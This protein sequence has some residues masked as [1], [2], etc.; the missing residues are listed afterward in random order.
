MNSLMNGFKDLKLQWK[1]ALGF[2]VP[3][4]LIVMIAFTVSSN[5][6]KLLE[7]NKWVEHTYK[8]IDLGKGITSSLVNMETGFRG[9]LVVGDKEFLEPFVSGQK[10]FTELMAKAK[11]MVSDNPTQVGR[12]K[13]VEGMQAGWLKEHVNIAMELRREVNA[14]SRSSTSIS[15]FINKGIGK[16]YM[17][18]MRVILDDFV[19][20]ES[21]LIV[22][23]GEE[24]IETA[25]T[26]STVTILGAILAVIIG[27]FV[28]YLITRMITKPMLK[29]TDALMRAQKTGDFNNRLIIA[30]KDEVGQA[31]EAFNLL[32][33]NLRD[34]FKSI[35]ESTAKFSKGDLGVR[36]ETKMMGDLQGMKDATNGMMD[37]IS[38]NAAA[39]V[40]N[41]RN[42]QALDVCQANVMMADA[43]LNIVYLNDSVKEMLSAAET[44]IQKDLPN[45]NVSSLMGFNVDGFHKNPSHQR[46]M[47][48]NLKEVYRTEIKV[49]GRAFSLVATPVFDKGERLGTVVEWNDR[50][51]ELVRLAEEQRIAADSFRIKRALD[52]CQANVMMADENNDI[53]YT[54]ET[55]LD[56][57]GTAERDIRKDLPNFRANTVN[58]SNIDIFHKNPA[59]QRGMLESLTASYDTQIEVGGRTFALIATPVFDDE[60]IRLGTVVEWND[61]TEELVRLAEEQQSAAENARV[62]QALDNLT[63][64]TMIADGDNNIVY[65]NQAV[66]D[67]LRN[68]EN[69]LRRELTNFNTDKVLGSNIDVFHK[70]PAHQRNM[71]SNLKSTY[72]TEIEVAGRTFGLIA[73]PVVDVD[74]NRIGTVVEWMDRTDEV[75]IEREID[76]VL[77][78]A[79]RGDLT[80]RIE[81]KGKDG[82]FKRLSEGLNGL[83]DIADGV[84]TETANVLGAMAQGDMTKTIDSDY[85][86]AFDQLKTDVNT[87]GERL[88]EIVGKISNSSGTIRT[89]A[90]EIAQGNADLSQRTEEQASSL[91]ETASSMEEMTS[92]V[93]QSAEN[94][95]TA[96]ELSEEAR[97]KASQGGDVVQR[98]IT[99]MD[100]INDSSKKIADIIGV[101]DEIAFQTNL[102]ALNAAVEAARAG[103][104][105]RGFAVVAGEVRNLAQ[106]SAGAAKEIKDL[107]R[108]SVDKVTDGSK[109]VNESGETLQEIVGAVGK[110]SD[111]IEGI[112]QAAEEQSAGIEQVNKAITQMDEMTQ[113]NAAL[114]EEASAAG[115]AMADQ[116]RGMQGLMDFFT[117]GNAAA[118]IEMQPVKSHKAA[119]RVSSA[120]L[121]AVKQKPAKKAAVP[122][123]VQAHKADDDEWEEF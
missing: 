96:N 120:P 18:G 113:Q 21:K 94:A 112:S 47:L 90:D 91:E 63:A 74:D 34:A 1:L 19:A 14:G 31:G 117:V 22:I 73:N 84:I 56:M 95:R 52:V 100:E 102:L 99:A 79:G 61:R 93:R 10:D 28:A 41:A 104:Q 50:T 7:T 76:G 4:L 9:Y 62:K 58:G 20:A 122:K 37:N 49:G 67:M 70:N 25:T 48:K 30:G 86:G 54:N 13:E 89:G 105:G 15:N 36:V 38:E 72:S 43:D 111:M 115:E 55:V 35:N 26:T 107:I 68:A 40:S 65:M 33:E 97:I 75:A 123:G 66:T 103:E 64:N 82:F 29:L 83:V 12:L 59:H 71:I 114:V 108:D 39:A 119:A 80:E 88:T 77:A 17:D 8:A 46:G 60:N 92:T 98:A 106:R 78:A 110:V 101:I 53:I 81:L 42:N 27:S 44:D 87:T 6:D 2:A 5:L 85:E 118:S 3:L 11:E 57:L 24:Q 23:R 32:L 121:K 109:L 51:E 45:F 69:D 16:G 116:A